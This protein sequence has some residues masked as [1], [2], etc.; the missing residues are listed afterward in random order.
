MSKQSRLMSGSKTES[1]FD[2]LWTE[3]M[4][5]AR[6]QRLE[7]LRKDK[8]GERKL[9][10]EVLRPVFGTTDG[11][12]MEYEL[13]STSGVKIYMDFYFE[14]MRCAIES[15]GYAVHAENITRD[16]FA[17]ERMRI[18]TMA[19]YG[20][21]YI[22]FAWDELDKKPEACRRSLYELLGRNSANPSDAYR[23]LT[24][25][26]RELIRSALRLN[27]PF[28][29]EDVCHC[30]QIGHIAGRRVL[31]GMLEKKL[32]ESTKTSFVRLHEFRLTANAV[33]AL[34]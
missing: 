19:M 31:R 13:T 33:Q 25:Y 22:P 15:D 3:Q 14:Q 10:D 2:R 16:R 27:R 26:E 6:G 24:V 9:F 30:L 29:M 4:R 34:M 18:R 23:Q 20:I 5:S 1:E 21:R 32:I 12:V 7:M 17:F 28:R 8:T 11:L